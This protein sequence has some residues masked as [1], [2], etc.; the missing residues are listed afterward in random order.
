MISS[1]AFA[2]AQSLAWLFAG[3]I[4]YGIGGGLVMACVAVAI[5]ELHPRQHVAAGALAASRWPRPPASPSAR[6]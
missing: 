2:A 6:S 4:I 3:E 1:V 5:R